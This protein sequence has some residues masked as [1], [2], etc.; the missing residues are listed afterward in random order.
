MGVLVVAAALIVAACRNEP[1]P[2][3]SDEF[4]ARASE[5][6]VETGKQIRALG[7]RTPAQFRDVA[8]TDT[9]QEMADYMGA[10]VKAEAESLDQL[11][12]LAPPPE[13]TE[14]IGEFLSAIDELIELNSDYATALR[15]ED[16]TGFKNIVEEGDTA[17]AKV[18]NLA[19]QGRLFGCTTTLGVP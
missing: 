14:M 2:L 17:E 16:L 19:A 12:E 13:M 18:A 5:I 15:A 1:E 7:V 3:S 9:Y 10:V 11:R 6:C 4:I 8:E